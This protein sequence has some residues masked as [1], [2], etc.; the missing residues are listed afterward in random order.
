MAILFTSVVS[1]GRLLGRSSRE[2]NFLGTK[3]LNQYQDFSS[4]IDD[5]AAVKAQKYLLEIFNYIL[6]NKKTKSTKK[7]LVSA[8][9]PRLVVNW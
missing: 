3:C 8:G 2:P 4:L 7:T 5:I 6:R 9:V 1:N